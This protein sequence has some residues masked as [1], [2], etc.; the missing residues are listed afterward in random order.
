M[1]ELTIPFLGEPRWRHQYPF[2]ALQ[3]AGAR[4]CG[5]SDWSVSSPDVLWGAHVAV[6][7]VAP[8]EES[9]ADT[10]VFLPGQRIDLATA[11]TAYTQG[12]AYVN[13][14]DHATGT[15]E[16]G[17]LADLVVLDRNPFVGPLEEISATRVSSTWVEGERVFTAQGLG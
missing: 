3:D 1:N 9:E 10:D 15:I 11:L 8:P 7:R 14:L 12:S 17:K 4:L 5:G 6:N 16:P 2:R 13:H